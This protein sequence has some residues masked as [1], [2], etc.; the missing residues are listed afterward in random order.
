[1]ILKTIRSIRA[2]L[3]KRMFSHSLKPFTPKEISLM[4]NLRSEFSKLPLE[5]TVNCSP[6]EKVWKENSNRFRQK[7]LSDDTQNF[8]RWN[9]ITE[10]MCV[11][12]E[13]FVEIEFNHL[14]RLQGWQE[15]WK[16]VIRET[17]V[18]HPTPFPLYPK[19]SANLIHHAYHLCQF[20]EKTGIK[21]NRF[22]FVFEFGGGYGGMC[23]MFHNLGF[24]G[25]YIIFDLPQF[26]A[27]QRYYLQSIG[28]PV[29]TDK[30]FGLSRSNVICISTIDDLK[31]AIESS[32]GNQNSLFLATWSMSEA[33]IGVRNSILELIKDFDAY[34]IAY[35]NY[36]HEIDNN[37]YFKAV[38]SKLNE[39][40]ACQDIKIEHLPGNSYLFG[41]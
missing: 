33:P 15:R 39:N 35:Q 9:V 30:S 36:F 31:T 11:C 26:S 32:I 22:N 37:K 3:T 6:A 21:I 34:L 8:L 24:K 17:S 40:I 12:N 29:Y 5:E 14:K 25:K 2:G 27:L 16:N 41:S 4:E 7:I 20:E 19:S 13:P 1:M 10:T 28:L 23:R 38:R 18:G